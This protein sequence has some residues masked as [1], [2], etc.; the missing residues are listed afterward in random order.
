MQQNR[1]EQKLKFR[2]LT[3]TVNMLEQ[4]KLHIHKRY[5]AEL[6]KRNQEWESGEYKSGRWILT[7]CADICICVF[8]ARSVQLAEREKEWRI[9]NKKLNVLVK[10]TENSNLEIYDMEDEIRNLTMEQKEEERQN[11]LHKKQLSN[12]L[13]LEEERVL[14]QIQVPG[15]QIFKPQ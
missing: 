14:L 9:F 4:K 12:K 1:E 5:E 7:V 11:D 3:D 15:S 10:M 6:Q 2:T 13:A 8:V